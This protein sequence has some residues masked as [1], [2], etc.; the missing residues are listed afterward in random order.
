MSLTDVWQIFQL[1]FMSRA[2]V[3]IVVIAATA[4]IVGLFVNLRNLEFVADG[5]THSVFPGLVIGFIVGGTDWIVGGALGAALIGAIALTI[6]DRRQVGSDA[7]TAVVLT[8]MFSIGVVLV[9]RRSGYVAELEQLLFGRL[10]T[11]PPGQ[12]T[13]VVVVCVVAALIIAVTARAQLFR[14][15]DVRGM[16][17]AGYR[18]LPVDLALNTA[19]ALIVVAGSQAIGNLMVLAM[20]IVPM[21]AARLITRR[22]GWLVPLA[23]LVAVGSATVG[24]VIGFELAVTH[25]V[26]ASPS[27]VAVLT[28]ITVYLII[29]AVSV[30][31]R[32]VARRRGGRGLLR[33]DVS[34]PPKG[35]VAGGAA[36]ARLGSAIGGAT[37]T[38]PAQDSG[39]GR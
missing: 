12:V 15:F 21:G 27:A 7:A 10:L 1:P 9:S 11:I 35:K 37:P 8:S 23:M 39:A 34:V 38:G 31:A 5:L 25:G 2:L 22:L 30:S 28:L 32:A 33:S 14:A 20:L 6:V 18:D 3:A 26:N 4:A 16:R 36:E 29:M 17:A 19:V 24:L 13:Q